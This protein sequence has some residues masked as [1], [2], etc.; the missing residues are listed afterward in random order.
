M[1]LFIEWITRIVLFLL[2]AMVADALLPSGLM[3]KYARLVMS[4]LLLLIFLGPLLQV[5]KVDPNQL[6]KT[7]EESMNQ[8]VDVMELDESIEKKKKE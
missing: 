8:Q 1:N 7:A 6:L 5:L 2:L 4:I 3:K